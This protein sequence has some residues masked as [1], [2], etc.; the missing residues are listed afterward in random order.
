MGS[1]AIHLV[2]KLSNYLLSIHHAS[3]T[4]LGPGNKMVS[5]VDML[6]II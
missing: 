5:K 4:M 1:K 2:L 6:C 3:D